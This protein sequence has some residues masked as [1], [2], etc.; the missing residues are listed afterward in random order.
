MFTL[1][2]DRKI[3]PQ[4][5]MGYL[6]GQYARRYSPRPNPFSQDMHPSYSPDEEKSVEASE[7]END[8]K[9][10]PKE[11]LDSNAPGDCVDENPNGSSALGDNEPENKPNP[12]S[13]TRQEA[14]NPLETNESAATGAPPPEPAVKT[15]P[16]RQWSDLSQ[17][18]QLDV[19]WTLCE[20]QFTG[21]MRLRTL[22]GDDDSG[23][24]W[25]MEPVGWDS[26]KNAYWLIGETR[27]WIQHHVP[28]PYKPSKKRGRAP[29]TT[30]MP[31]ESTV[32]S[33]VPPSFS[34]NEGD[35]EEANGAQPENADEEE[36]EAEPASS[37]SLTPPPAIQSK[38]SSAR[39]S[40]SSST[41]G[42]RRTNESANESR[43]RPKVTG[44]RTNG[45]I[46]TTGQSTLPKPMIRLD[47][48]RT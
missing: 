28:Q 29:Q 13:T 27:L 48:T 14:A 36:S 23:V 1:A 18:E 45:L 9:Q 34:D 12:E 32:S 16:M 19:L 3:T 38:I 31:I 30:V 8:L 5:W 46:K 47:Q 21:A 6:Q 26:K 41:T 39:Q 25:R 24:G 44:T 10:A 2:Q 7:S 11:G 33:S 17:S 35:R 15:Q 42:K 20:W 4:N 40:R 37:R 22:L 43:K